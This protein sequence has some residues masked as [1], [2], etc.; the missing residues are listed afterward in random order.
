MNVTFIDTQTHTVKCNC[1][2]C[3][4]KHPRRSILFIIQKQ[5]HIPPNMQADRQARV[6]LCQ[7]K[8]VR[9]SYFCL[10]RKYIEKKRV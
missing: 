3:V 6:N 7:F 5:Q 2:I 10:T 1:D 9:I 4:E 8:S